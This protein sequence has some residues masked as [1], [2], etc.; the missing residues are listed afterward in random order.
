MLPIIERYR[1]GIAADTEL[2]QA[3]AEAVVRLVTDREAARKMGQSGREGSLAELN[4]EH[5]IQPLIEWIRRPVEK[6]GG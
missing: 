6:A 5:E 1:C 4:V 3:I 2:P